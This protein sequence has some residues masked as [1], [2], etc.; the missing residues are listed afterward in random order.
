MKDE[1][2]IVLPNIGNIPDGYV[3]VITSWS[4]KTVKL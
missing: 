4:K 1:E 2:I 3:Q